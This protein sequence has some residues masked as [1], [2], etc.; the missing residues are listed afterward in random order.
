MP[1]FYDR[2][3]R[4]AGMWINAARKWW[5]GLL[6]LAFIL[7]LA[8]FNHTRAIEADLTA[9]ANAA[10]TG[11]LLNDARV[12]ARGRDLDLEASAFTEQGRRGAIAI[13][14][15][16][17]GVRRVND[18]TYLLPWVA[19]YTW[20]ARR[21][22]NRIVLDGHVPLPEVREGLAEVARRAGGNP[23]VT[24][25]MIYSR[26]APPNFEA[27]ARLL[28]A[29]LAFLSAGDI[30]ISDSA[31]KIGG[32]AR[33]PGGREAILQAL[34]NLPQS[35][36]LTA[37]IKAPPYVFQANKDPVSATLNLSGNAPDNA[38]RQIVTAAGRKFFADSIIDNLRVSLG[39][40]QGFTAA[41][42]AGL[43]DL[44][45][46]STGSLV[47]SDRS[48]KLAGDAFHEAAAAQIRSTLQGRLP[49][50]WQA[51]LEISVK[52]LSAP[53]DSAVCQRLFSE[54]LAKGYIRFESAQAVID[55]DS[56]ALLD[57]LAAV[58]MRC[59]ATPVE[60]GGH[61]DSDGDEQANMTLSQR[62]AQTVVDYLVAAGL[63][64]DRLTAVGYG[65]TRPIASNDTVEGKT[66]NRRIEFTVK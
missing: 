17:S 65:E 19:P 23:A 9:R 38:R 7:V 58:A 64:A 40:P 41:A 34:G 43:S 57:Q 59:P 29:E 16:V 25:R 12:A 55:P 24:D 51:E 45:R 26:G 14:E 4:T 52:P 47:M 61:T 36:T 56:H 15:G 32:M 13:A 53:V 22:G 11:I 48:V 50:G 20:S 60:I 1:I 46:L 2:D 54:I 66:Y 44:S 18:R 3:S 10:L 5:L 33:Q 42:L 28:V 63:S 35:F 8:A 39:A 6:P 37:D 27:A 30:S 21:D 62:R 49:Q 31:V